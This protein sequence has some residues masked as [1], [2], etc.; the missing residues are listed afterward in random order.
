[1]WLPFVSILLVEDIFNFNA[2]PKL[3]KAL[4]DAIS[5]V[6][7]THQHNLFKLGIS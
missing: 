7:L 1:M 5:L 4:K 3:F 2:T 6:S